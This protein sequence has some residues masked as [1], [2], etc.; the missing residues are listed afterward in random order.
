MPSIRKTPLILTAMTIEARAVERELADFGLRAQ[1]VGMKACKLPLDAM[2]GGFSCVVMAGLGGALDPTLRIGDVII[3]HQIPEYE[4]DSSPQYPLM[5]LNQGLIHTVDRL[6]CSPEEKSSLFEETGAQVVDMENAIVRRAAENAG[7]PFIGI[8]AVS[9]TAAQSID[10]EVVGLV[11]DMGRPRPIAAMKL[12][13]RRPR[14]AGQL[15]RLNTDTQV[16]LKSLRLAVR[17]VIELL[18]RNT[19]A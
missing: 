1:A 17:E 19:A 12:I 18:Q 3:D 16:A 6:I 7:L 15:K 2:F 13:A 4:I 5:R 14:M 8:R 10:Q 9:D 11:D